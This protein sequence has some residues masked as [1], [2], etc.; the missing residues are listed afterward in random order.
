MYH[1]H[2]LWVYPA[3]YLLYIKMEIN[4]DAL[5]SFLKLIHA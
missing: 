3:V 5:L 1:E 2:S 4:D